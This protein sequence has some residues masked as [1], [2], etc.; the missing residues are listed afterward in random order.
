MKSRNRL[1]LSN[2]IS[3]TLYN[4]KKEY[5]EALKSTGKTDFYKFED[6]IINS[7]IGGGFG[8]ANDFEILMIFGE[9]GVGKSRLMLNCLAAAIKKKVAIRY[10][11]LEDSIGETMVRLSH[12]ISE[13]E[14]FEADCEML[15]PEHL[16]DKYEPKLLLEFIEETFA[17]DEID[18]LFIDHIQFAFEGTTAVN[19]F[20]SEVEKH[21]W[22]MKRINAICNKYKKTIVLSSH[23]NKSDSEGLNKI[24]GSSALQQA[25][26]KVIEIKRDKNEQYFLHCWKSRGTRYTY[27][28]IPIKFEN[29]FKIVSNEG[30]LYEQT[31]L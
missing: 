14:M 30:P 2:G 20:K 19:D 31:D 21:R 27:E 6:P 7:H 18:I 11:L 25:A 5:L 13:K 9:T 15:T 12:I 1:K 10:L 8:K 4:Y 28:D 17:K 16:K 23:T 29:F 3:N 24:L 26:T 22:I